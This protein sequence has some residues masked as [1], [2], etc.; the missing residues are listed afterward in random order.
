MRYLATTDRHAIALGY[1][2]RQYADRAP[3]RHVRTGAALSVARA[4][5]AL[6]A[7]RL[8]AVHAAGAAEDHSPG[9]AT[10]QSAAIPGNARRRISVGV[11]RSG[12]PRRRQ[13]A[14]RGTIRPHQ[15]SR[16]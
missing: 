8:F 14:W 5:W 13:S 2:N 6:E 16:I 1:S 7:A 15:G 11:A 12:Y 4:G 3:R 9:R 10:A